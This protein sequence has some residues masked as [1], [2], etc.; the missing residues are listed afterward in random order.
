MAWVA[1]VVQGDPWSGNFHMPWAQ[2]KKA[3]LLR[4]SKNEQCS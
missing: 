3:A 1:A 4:N 2:A